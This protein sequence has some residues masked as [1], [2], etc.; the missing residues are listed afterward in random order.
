MGL[1]LSLISLSV[2]GGVLLAIP[3]GNPLALEERLRLPLTAVVS[4]LIGYVVF[5]VGLIP[6]E[7]AP[8]IAGVV[9]SWLPYEALPALVSLF[10]AAV[11]LLLAGRRRE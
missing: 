6:L 1:F 3:T 9:A 7:R 8:F 2:I 10:F 11:G 4:G 5:A